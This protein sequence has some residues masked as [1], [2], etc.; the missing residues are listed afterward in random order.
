[1]I[2]FMVTIMTI[3]LRIENSLLSKC[4]I[5]NHTEFFFSFLTSS[6]HECI[7]LEICKRSGEIY[8]IRT[9][10]IHLNGNSLLDAVEVL[11]IMVTQ[12]FSLFLMSQ[13]S[14]L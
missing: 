11:E 8:I 13:T 2:S 4:R 1:M 9:R 12:F 14:E 3:R 10:F 7:D 5:R 6:H